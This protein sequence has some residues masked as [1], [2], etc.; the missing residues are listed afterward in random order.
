MPSRL[1]ALFAIDV[2]PLIPSRPIAIS[3]TVSAIAISA[4][5]ATAIATPAIAISASITKS[6]ITAVTFILPV[7]LEGTSRVG[8]VLR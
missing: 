1:V 8:R 7:G 4:I 2:A 6:I 5:S 3:V